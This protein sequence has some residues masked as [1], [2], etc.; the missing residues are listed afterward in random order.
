M[1]QLFLITL[2]TVLTVFINVG[3]SY[4]CEEMEKMIKEL[5]KLIQKYEDEV[6]PKFMKKLKKIVMNYQLDTGVQV[7]GVNEPQIPKNARCI[8][9]F[10]RCA[11]SKNCFRGQTGSYHHKDSYNGNDLRE[12]YVEDVVTSGCALK[13]T[14]DVTAN[15]GFV[16]YY[17]KLK[18]ADF[19]RYTKLYLYVKGDLEKRF[20][21]KFKI[22]LK[23]N[24][25]KTN[26]YMITR[27]NS[28]W[29]RVEIPLSKFGNPQLLKRMN[30]L[31][32]T[33][34][35]EFVTKNA[36]VVYIDDIYVQ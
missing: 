32:I 12:N 29:K 36:G 26:F 31:V 17:S 15:K 33:F 10:N 25:G 35:P 18:G 14:Y 28:T 23:P 7:S 3:M 27:I 30:E 19:S 8:D 13:L 1:K 24:R 2:I 9:D 34:A 22:E 5:N 11:P 4:P 21:S 16:G 20:T 6:S